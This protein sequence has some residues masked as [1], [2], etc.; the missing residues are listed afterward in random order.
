MQMFFILLIVGGAI[1]FLKGIFTKK[2]VSSR[3]LAIPTVFMAGGAATTFLLDHLLQE[4][5]FDQ[6]TIDQLRQMD[7][8][9]LQNFALEHHI[10]N[11]EQ[12]HQL[13]QQMFEQ[14]QINEWMRQIHDP[15]L[16]PG[17]DHVVDETVHGID[18]GIGIANPVHHDH[19]FH[20]GS[21]MDGF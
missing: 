12:L 2:R 18:H 4:R 15:Y 8:I 14:I 3:S 5:D 17:L 16:N 11:T 9:H 20:H 1:I 19:S 21:G 10:W 6:A 13:Q 7:F